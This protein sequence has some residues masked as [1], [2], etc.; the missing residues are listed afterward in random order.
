MALKVESGNLNNQQ[1]T[2]VWKVNNRK[3]RHNY[4][5]K[6]IYKFSLQKIGE[7]SIQNYRLRC[8]VAAISDESKNS[9]NNNTSND[10]T[11]K[12]LREFAPQIEQI[13]SEQS[14]LEKQLK[15]IQ[16]LLIISFVI[17]IVIS[18]VI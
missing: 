7:D 17:T 16:L 9:N 12:L 14:K 8:S 11:M 4:F 2:E 3:K 18:F 6:L 15:Q 1:L 5:L 10:A 13:L